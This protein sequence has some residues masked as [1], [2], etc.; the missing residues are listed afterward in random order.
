MATGNEPRSSDED[1]ICVLVLPSQNYLVNGITLSLDRFNVHQL[2]LRGG[3]SAAS[4]LE[5]ALSRP[6]VRDH[7][8]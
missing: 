4:G 5:P 3:S 7:N 2:L 6:Q 8:H 1:D